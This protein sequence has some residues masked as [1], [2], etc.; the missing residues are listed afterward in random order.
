MSRPDPVYL[1]YNATAP[2]R[3]EAYDAVVCAL[4]LGA[5]PSSVHAGGRM[6]RAAVE[7][8]RG[9][10]ARLIGARDDQV[11]FTSGG[12]E[13]NRMA[14]E[15]AV[16]AGCRRPIVLA[17]EHDSTMRAATG[18]GHWVEAWPVSSQ[19]LADLDW[20]R[21]RLARWDKTEGAP[22]V[23]VSLANSETGVI[24]P[25]AEIAAI[26][27]EAGG[28]LHVDAVQA[29]GKIAVD[30]EALGA[31][32]LSLSGH[33]LGAPQGVG[34]LVIG[35]RVRL[36]PRIPMAGGQERGLRT[37]TEN[38]SGI[39]GMGAAA[40]AALKDIAWFETP[41][42]PAPHHDDRLLT[43]SPLRHPEEPRSG[44]SKDAPQAAW[45][46]AAAERLKAEGAVIAGEG[47]PRLPGVL[48]ALTAGFPSELQVMMLDL[49][50]VMVSAGSACSSGK[51]THS[52]VLAAMGYGGEAWSAL[53]ADPDARRKLGLAAEAVRASGG[54]ATTEADW[55]R[56][57]D[58]WTEA[59]R[60]HARRR[61]VA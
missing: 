40:T 22:F 30:I 28:A 31:D 46:D 4:R 8:A 5:N 50:G 49:E 15:G 39:A 44:I 48:S 53:T 38:V 6:A 61:Q 17:T 25:V 3:P 11:V 23:A 41:A 55:I 32:T 45:R 26:V 37:G 33:K 47:A 42:A 56:F 35:P 57:A 10:V 24:Q 52:A 1:D 36:S 34:A 2:I 27:H 21:G 13:A 60:R 58:A 16:A 54:W 29:A 59:H 14:V 12:T 7:T 20:L 18:S 9:E 51:V 43:S 19:G